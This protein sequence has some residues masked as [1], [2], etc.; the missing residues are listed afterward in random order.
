MLSSPRPF[1]SARIIADGTSVLAAEI[2]AAA[3]MKN[4]PRPRISARKDR[5]N[6]C[7]RPTLGVSRR[8]S[9]S[10]YPRRRKLRD[11][12]RHNP[13]AP[14]EPRHRSEYRGGRVRNS[15]SKYESRRS[16]RIEPLARTPAN[17]PGSFDSQ[18]CSPTF[19]AVRQIKL[20][21]PPVLIVDLFEL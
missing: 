20:S 14:R 13:P 21:F 7:A 4:D 8:I 2:A 18:P 10:V 11:C 12:S 1:A 6:C 19:P 17:T 5:S 15:L 9:L 16:R 3:Y